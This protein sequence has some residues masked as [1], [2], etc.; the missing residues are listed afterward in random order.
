MTPRERVKAALRFQEFDRVPVE[1]GRKHNDVLNVVGAGILKFGPGKTSGVMWRKGTRTDAWGCV[2]EMAEDG[3]SG[4]VKTPILSDW[5]KL[6]ALQPPWDVL[7]EAD[8]S[9][10]NAACAQTD[11]FTA[12]M[13][14][15]VQPFQRMQYLRGTETLFM[16][17]AY[18]EAEVYRLRDLV[19]EFYVKKLELV[20]KT[21]LDAV[22]IEDDWGSQTNLL[23]SPDMWREFFKPLYRD[24]VDIA[25]AHR[26]AIIMHSDGQ[27]EAILPELVEIG[28]DAVNA[29]LDCMDVES[30]ASR[31]HHK[32]AFWGGFDRQHLLPH[33]TDAEIRAEV[34]RIANAFF[35]YGRTG[36]VGQCFQDKGVRD[37]A[38]DAVYDE[39]RKV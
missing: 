34:R 17:L 5:S 24:Y 3:V 10:V 35:R 1:G 9:Q 13:W 15:D 12:A 7:K 8:L 22:H 27:I 26:K 2:F 33:G 20:C 32:I 11:R 14:G 19:H 39:W 21:D 30:I 36:I 23:V 31:F 18:G 28:L 29:Q 37:E 25:H 38:V 6:D 4:E 16:D